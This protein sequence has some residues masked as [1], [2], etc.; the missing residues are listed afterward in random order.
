MPTIT[1]TI[2]ISAK[3]TT[4]GSSNYLEVDNSAMVYMLINAVKEQQT[5][6]AQLQAEV[7]QLKNVKN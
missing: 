6:I 2:S 1:I 5:M 4:D 7:Q 3:E